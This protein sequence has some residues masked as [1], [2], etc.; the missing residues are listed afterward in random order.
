MPVVSFTPG[1]MPSRLY[2]C[3]LNTSKSR[4]VYPR[5]CLGA[6]RSGDDPIREVTVVSSLLIYSR[7]SGHFTIEWTIVTQL[8][9][10]IRCSLRV[11]THFPDEKV[12]LLV[13][14]VLAL[15]VEADGG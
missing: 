5:V 4:C 3:T 11:P 1:W 14:G 10:A 8:I 13:V 12:L 9:S 7:Y 6:A 15:R 2:R